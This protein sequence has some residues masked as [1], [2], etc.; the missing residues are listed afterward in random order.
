LEA[1]RDSSVLVAGLI[2]FCLGS[3]Q[4][5]ERWRA[6]HAVRTLARFGRWRVIDELFDRLNG[7]DAGAFQDP[8]LPF[9]VI[10]ARQW[11]LLAIARIAIDFPVEI[12]HH[13]KELEAIAF[14]ETFP[15]LALREAARRALF[16][17]LI[18]DTSEGADALRERLKAIH[19]SKF[20]PID[21]PASESSGFYGTRPEDVPKSDPPFYFDYDFG[22]YEIA[23]VGNM[24][25]LPHWQ[26]ED[27]CIAW[28]RKWDA[29]IE[30]M[31]DF[32]GR[33][34][35]SGYS[36][37]ATGAED[38]FQSYGAYLAR[39]ALALEAG[40]LLL[41]TPINDS[42]YTDERWDEWLSRSSPTRQDGCGWPMALAGIPT[43][44]CTTSRKKARKGCGRQLIRHS[45]LPSLE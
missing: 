24:F 43:S 39:H 33:D 3:P 8:R 18:T 5:A 20:L 12:A 19:V 35:P 13:A 34:R 27:A 26:V 31:H 7:S 1:A 36:P 17:C 16:A 28:I 29:K 42:R 30:R 41:T 4:A 44:A 9:F 2:W 40:R 25:G 32:G 22:K 45:S 37:Y 38:S 11:F 10:H 21:L 6:A 23:S 15:H 14:D